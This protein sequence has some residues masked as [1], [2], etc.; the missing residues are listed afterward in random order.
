MQQHSYLGLT[1]HP[2]VSVVKG[3]DHDVERA[4]DILMLGYSAVLM[5]PLFAP[6]APP[7]ILLPLMALSFILSVCFARRNFYGIKQKLATAITM[8]ESQELSILRPI[9]DI[10][11]EH[12]EQTLSDSFNPLKNP[13]RT[14]KSVLGGIIMN[15]FWM[16][17]FYTLGMQFVE[18]KQFFLLNKAVICV[19][20]KTKHW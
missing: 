7:K 5:A 16:P 1:N 8:L 3:V 13:K 2:V 4:E 10:F 11:K 9:T 19:E 20:D 6:I 17:I 15:P 12:P 14:L 18:D